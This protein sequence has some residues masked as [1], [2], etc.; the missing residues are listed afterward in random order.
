MGA[1]GR[2]G[3]EGGRVD[4]PD[5]TVAYYSATWK[6]VMA[7]VGSAAFVISSVW[8]LIVMGG[9]LS[10]S[11]QFALMVV[12]VF[13]TGCLVASVVRW[14]LRGP[15]L[16]VTTREVFA[17]SLWGKPRPGAALESVLHVVIWTHSHNTN[18]GVVLRPEAETDESVKKAAARNERWLSVPAAVC[19][20]QVTLRTPVGD[21]GRELAARCGC[22]LIDMRKK[23]KPTG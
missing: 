21:V 15:V 18:L 13:F 19:V 12:A 10:M 4:L 22:P 9:Q 14:W 2:G 11:R 8:L 1:R 17:P 7:M 5:G 6:L 16:V 20:G 3:R 23:A